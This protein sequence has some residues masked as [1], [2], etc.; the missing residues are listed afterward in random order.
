MDSVVHFEMPYEDKDRA[1]SFYEKAFGWKAQKLG[2]EMGEYVVVHTAETDENNMVKKPGAING[3]LF[4]RSKPEQV[5]S[6]V[7]SVDDIRAAMKRV[8]EAGGKVLGGQTPGEPDEIPGIGLYASII[9]SEGNQIGML[10]PT[11]M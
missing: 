3:G 7:V 9:D 1:A 2:A 4:K 8:E 5:P 6:V 11:R 10:Q